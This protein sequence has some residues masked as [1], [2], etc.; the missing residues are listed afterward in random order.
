MNLKSLT[1]Y[2]T[3]AALLPLT[4]LALD[5]DDQSYD[6]EK[7]YDSEINKGRPF[8]GKSSDFLI[9]RSTRRL[10]NKNFKSTKLKQHI[11]EIL[12]VIAI[13]TLVNEKKYK[14][15][16]RYLK[17]RTDDIKSRVLVQKVDELT[18]LPL[19]KSYYSK[20]IEDMY[21]LTDA[22]K[23]RAKSVNI[24]D[25]S[26]KRKDRLAELERHLENSLKRRKDREVPGKKIEIDRGLNDD[27]GESIEDMLTKRNAPR[28]VRATNAPVARFLKQTS[29]GHHHRHIH[30][31][32]KHS[33]FRKLKKKN[34]K[35]RR[36]LNPK[37][38]RRSKMTRKLRT[39]LVNPKHHKHRKT[40][41]I[42]GAPGGGGGV[43]QGAGVENLKVVI[44]AIGQPSSYLP[45]EQ[46]DS[47]KKGYK[48]ADAEPR[49]IV[50][51]MTLPNR[52]GQ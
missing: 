14:K 11:W 26:K 52:I 39:R 42:P 15:P 33:N 31:L 29:R 22:D 21:T 38:H 43:T 6:T 20:Y 49:V 44:N 10:L 2:L 37:I 30:S 18:K 35:I 7:L 9:L 27:D 1:F 19:L 4:P 50:T 12:K 8:R 47:Y 25:T 32:K 51:R 23:K 41:G 36:N 28:T 5:M 46:N 17:L 40:F 34:I 45:V 24:F 3:L 16:P 13:Y 48:E